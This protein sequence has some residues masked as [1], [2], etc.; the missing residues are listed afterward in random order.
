MG[1]AGAGGWG[2]FA[3]TVAG[4]AFVG[5]ALAGC[6]GDDEQTT[7]PTNAPPSSEPVTTP[8]AGPS[9]TDEPTPTPVPTASPTPVPP[10][11]PD[12]IEVLER[13]DLLSGLDVPW[14]LA[15]TADGT[16]VLTLRERAALMV[17]PPGGRPA[18]VAGPGAEQLVDVVAPVGEAGL[19]GVAVLGESAA[20]VDLVLYATTDTDN[21]VLRGTLTGT[22]LGELTPILTGIPH[23]SYHDGG[24]LAVGPDGCLYVSTGDAGVRSSSQDLDSLGGKILR[25]TA[26]GHPAPGN[27]FD[28]SPVWSY[29]HRNVQ[30][31]GW[32]A[33]GRMFASEFGQDTWDELNLVVPGG[34][35]G[36]PLVEGSDGGDRG[37]VE[38]LA[39]WR[40]DDASPS[41]LAVTDEGVYL[42]GLRGQVLWRLPLR[43]SDE[44]AGVG[45][46]QALLDGVLGRLRAV[47]VAPDGSLTVLTN[48]T[49]GRGTPRAG[50]D[51]AVRVVVG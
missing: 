22:S 41:G 39:T 18:A 51:R 50:D 14:G 40:T 2:P 15:Y 1:T 8:S 12:T 24:R 42:A 23:A 19:L 36:W 37:L 26:T 47:V 29:G 9:P 20:G 32:A 35:Y 31:M 3:R 25:I 7:S 13:G 28:G 46:A 17:V 6:T 21:R 30:G 45:R 49:D 10:D 33:D 5:L 4:L 11:G 48:N 27:P 34:N 16:A 43:P 44:G 38:P